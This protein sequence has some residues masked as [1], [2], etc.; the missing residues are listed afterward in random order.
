VFERFTDRGRRAVIY[1]QEEARDLGHPFIGAEHLLLGVARTDPSLLGVDEARLRSLV[2]ETL[3]ASLKLVEGWIPFTP[4]AKSAIEHALAVAL[5]RHDRH[6]GPTQLLLA[7]LEQD[8]IRAIA[9]DAGAAPAE[10][11]ARLGPSADP[12]PA[13]DGRFTDLGDARLLLEMV[14]RGGR[15]AE[16]L[17]EQGVDE[18]AIRTRFGAMDLGAD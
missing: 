6:I 11:M 15:V 2:V 14:L 1:A 9:H 16:W 17:R 18:E 8:G 12:P 5:A 3:G 7:L 4:E 13:E 10:V